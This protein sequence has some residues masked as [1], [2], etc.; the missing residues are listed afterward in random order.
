MGEAV[1]KYTVTLLVA[2]GGWKQWFFFFMFWR[3]PHPHCS[4]K[5]WSSGK[6]DFFLFF[7]F[8]SSKGTAAEKFYFS[9]FSFLLSPPTNF[10]VFFIPFFFCLF[11]FFFLFSFFLLFLCHTILLLEP[12][13]R[14]SHVSQ[15]R[16]SIMEEAKASDNIASVPILAH[17][18]P[19]LHINLKLQRTFSLFQRRE[20][21]VLPLSQFVSFYSLVNVLGHLSGLA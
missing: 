13:I 15:S 8:F 19:L 20:H 18:L 14:L 10:L 16:P 17:L 4:L 2:S 1:S 3:S 5:S 7:L 6:W 12:R 9:P 11:S 21:F